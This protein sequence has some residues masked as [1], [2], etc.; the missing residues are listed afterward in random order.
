MKQNYVEENIRRE[1]KRN[2]LGRGEEKTKGT[3]VKMAHEGKESSY[4]FPERSNF[5]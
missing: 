1:R 4:V 2:F 3:Q 5:E